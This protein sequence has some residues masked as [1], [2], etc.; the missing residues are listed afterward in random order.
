MEVFGLQLPNRALSN[1]DILK[2][3]GHLGIPH[4]RG[5][6]MK[7]TLPNI[8]LVNECG[9]VDFNATFEPESHWV[10]YYKTGD[11]RIHFDSY[12]QITL[13]EMQRYLKKPD[14]MDKQ[15][16]QRNTDIVQVPGTYTSG[17]LCLY[18]LKSLSH[19]SSFRDGL[20]SLTQKVKDD[21]GQIP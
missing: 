15:V 9:I 8:P 16:I 17:H 20:N 6:F 19:S 10:A 12:G 21:N 7:D 1:F 4:F 3:V 2:Y 14:E 18:I 13:Y 5:V 11:L